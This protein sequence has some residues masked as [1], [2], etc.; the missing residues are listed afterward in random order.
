MSDKKKKKIL[1]IDLGFSSLKI[2]VRDD[3]G[4]LIMDRILNVVAKLPEEPSESDD[5]SVFRFL[6][7]FYCVGANA[8]KMSRE[9]QLSIETIQDLKAIYP[10]WLS[11]IAKKYGGSEGFNAFSK[12]IIGL[13]PAFADYADEI[14]EHIYDTLLFQPGDRNLFVV[15]PQ[16]VIA[17]KCIEKYNLSLRDTDAA[18][19]NATKM[20]NYIIIDSGMN[21]TDLAVI[22]SGRSSMAGSIGLAATGCINICYK[23]V[24]YIYHNF[25]GLKITVK[26]AME[27]M[28]Q[29]VYIRRRVTYP[30]HDI[31]RQFKKEFIADTLN[32]LETNLGDELDRVEGVYWLG[33]GAHIYEE[34]KDDPEVIK[35]VTKHFPLDFLKTSENDQEFF[36][37]VAYLLVG[38]E[39]VEKGLI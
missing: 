36:N 33:G 8:L 24:D 5:F 32:L 19:R 3:F 35:E 15:L 38:E 20:K 9:S 2:S 11:Y 21:S 14:L 28:E 6:D 30:L 4:S 10:I 25:N 12:I 34:L 37:S 31:V 18:N 23:I 26:E 16:G 29:E 39:M 1:S 27:V 13:S 17:K 22:T 7:N